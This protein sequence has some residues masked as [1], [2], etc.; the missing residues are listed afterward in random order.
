[1]AEEV[2]NLLNEYREG[3][4][5]RRDFIQKAAILTGSLA[6]ANSLLEPLFAPAAYAAQV[7]PSDP[8][9]SS[10]AVQFAGP[11]SAISGYLT[12]PKAGGKHPAIVV[13]HENRGINDHTRDVA[14]RL[15]KEG[16]VALAPDYLS[17][18]GGTEKV[19]PKGE[20]LSNIRQL[21][22][23][24]TVAED[25]DAALAYL[26]SLPDVRGDRIGVVG[27]CWGG[28]MTF[29]VATYSRGLRAVVVYYG[30]SPNPLDLV[31]K[32]E[33]PV[34]AHYGGEDKGVNG[35]IAA[36]EAA[37]KKYNK[38]YNYKIYPGAQHGFNNDTGGSRYHPEAAK[39]AWGRTLEYFKKQLQG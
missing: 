30:R 37:M 3:R 35:G 17:R 16:Y 24:K 1:M 39:E 10:S 32:I 31:E 18:G 21:A 33:A 4:I 29:N 38:G 23:V 15:A 12:K 27:F 36:T 14:R 6:M 26:R 13:I 5:S 34:L 9:L 8:A 7:D 22:P 19:N 25:T 20:G 2:K 28:E 11:A